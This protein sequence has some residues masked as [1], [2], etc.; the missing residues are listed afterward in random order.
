VEF[1]I[2]ASL[3]ENLSLVGNISSIKARTPLGD[4]QLFRGVADNT[5]AAFVSYTL[6]RKGD[7]KGL[8]LGAGIDYVSKRAGDNPNPGGFIAASSTPTHLVLGQPT[9]YLPARTLVSLMVSYRLDAHW[10]AQLNVDN[11]FNEHYLAAST[12]RNNVFPGTPINPRVTVNYS[13]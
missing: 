13:F 12:S 11:L 7:F 1:E 3:T 10:K 6:D 8:A 2:N 4:G 9:F 5:A